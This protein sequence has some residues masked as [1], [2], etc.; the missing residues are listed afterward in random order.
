MNLAPWLADQLRGLLAQRGHAWLLQG[1]S[2]LGQYG[3]A[4]GLAQAWLCDNPGPGGACGT[5]ASCH[6]IEVR[7]HTDLC[8]LMPET[9]MLDLGWP[10]CARRSSSPSAPAAAGGARR[11]WCIR[12]NA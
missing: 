10:P 9:V 7:G 11:C 3:L 12:P 5:C 2:G 1:P 6:A 8:V 4:L